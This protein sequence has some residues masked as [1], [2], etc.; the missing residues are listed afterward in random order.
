MADAP[1]PERPASLADEKTAAELAKLKAET[2]KLNVE[3]ARS[4]RLWSP[5][6][7]MSGVVSVAAVVV[8]GAQVWMANTAQ[9]SADRRAEADR[10][11]QDRRTKSDIWLRCIETALKSAEYA[12]KL[13]ED[14]VKAGSEPNPQRQVALMNVVIATFPPGT[15]RRI[16][17]AAASEGG[18]PAVQQ[19]YVEAR[20]ALPPEDNAACLITDVVLQR[21]PEERTASAELPTAS[22]TGTGC[23]PNPTPTPLGVTVFPQIVREDDKVRAQQILAGLVQLAPN[24][25]VKAIDEV[26]SHDPKRAKA[27]IRY[28]YKD[29][30]DI[31][32]RLTTLLAQVGCLEGKGGIGT[33]QPRYIGDRF[34]NLPRGRIELWFPAQPD[35]QVVDRQAASPS[36]WKTPFMAAWMAS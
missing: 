27:E 19:R 33:F 25:V 11:E 28:Y 20:D 29:Q 10:Q 9:V 12:A 5:A 4:R 32:E 8:S 26:P 24:T 2:A 30:E 18:S 36:S 17:Q 13:R 34:S 23:K 6:G 16:L 35:K 7:I 22:L 15:A 14:F 31:A 21:V 1:T 3:N